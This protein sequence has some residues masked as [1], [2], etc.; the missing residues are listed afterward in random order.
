LTKGYCSF[1]SYSQP[2]AN[3]FLI[4]SFSLKIWSSITFLLVIAMLTSI[5]W[6]QGLATL[7]SMTNGFSI[8]FT[9]L[10]LNIFYMS[11]YSWQFMILCPM[12]P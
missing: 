4:G 10:F 11:L 12:S 6:T 5:I 9:P 7:G 2:I 8:I 1:Y 3:F